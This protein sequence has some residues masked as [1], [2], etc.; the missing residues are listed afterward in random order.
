VSAERPEEFVVRVTR[1]IAEIRRSRGVTQDQLAEVLG[2]ATR[3]VQRLEA[4]QNVTLH[5]LARIAAALDVTAADL[6][7]TDPVRPPPPRRYAT[8][9]A[10][11]AH[12]VSE[13]HRPRRRKPV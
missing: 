3:N 9:S 13:R 5:T 11:A 7:G 12:T 2:T 4:G 10:S 8:P 6:V 1:R